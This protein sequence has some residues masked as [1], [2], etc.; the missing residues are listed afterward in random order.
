[1]ITER[2]EDSV[3]NVVPSGWDVIDEITQGGFGKGELILWQLL[4][5]L[6]NHGH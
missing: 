4:Q 2:Y 5:V 3:R 1:M 6:V